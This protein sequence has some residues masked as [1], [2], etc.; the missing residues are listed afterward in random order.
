H[1]QQELIDGAVYAEVLINQISQIVEENKK[2]KE[3]LQAKVIL[4]NN[5][6][7]EEQYALQEEVTKYREA[8]EKIATR[9]M[10]C[11]LSESHMNQDFIKIAN[12]ALEESK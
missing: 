3:Q 10:S 2:L 4:V 12:E 6:R 5:G 9:K 11:Y 7:E 8:L 1:I